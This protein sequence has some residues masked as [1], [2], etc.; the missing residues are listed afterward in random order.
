MHAAKKWILQVASEGEE[1]GKDRSLEVE[2]HQEA[3]GDPCQKET[4]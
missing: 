2:P 1:A 3:T 4:N